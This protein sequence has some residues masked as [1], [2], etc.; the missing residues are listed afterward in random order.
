MQNNNKN[1]R[2]KTHK[3]KDAD[4]EATIGLTPKKV[5]VWNVRM[6]NERTNERNPALEEPV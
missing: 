3:K 4:P 1:V 2:V 6:Y 5:R